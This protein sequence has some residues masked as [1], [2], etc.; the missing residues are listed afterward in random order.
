MADDPFAGRHYERIEYPALTAMEREA[1]ADA[2]TVLTKWLEHGEKPAIIGHLA[3]RAA[4]Q[5]KDKSDHEWRMLFEDYAEDLAEFSA[6]HVQ[7]AIVWYRRTSNFFPSIAELRE[8]CLELRARDTV[9][10][11]RARRML[12]EAA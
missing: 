8:R 11:E 6:R 3:R 5:V 10:L 9:R 12:K 2:A 1:V 7:E 4:H